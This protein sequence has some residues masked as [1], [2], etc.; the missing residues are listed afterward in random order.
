VAAAAAV[1][2]VSAVTVPVLA[3]RT[4]RTDR[5]LPPVEAPTSAA[6]TRAKAQRLLLTTLG[7]VS[8]ESGLAEVRPDG[9]VVHHKLPTGADD[10]VAMPDGHLLTL[11]TTDLQPGTKRADGPGVAG[12][13]IKLAVLTADGS[14][15]R[16]RE[17]R[18]KGEEVRLLG[19]TN[20]TA[21][22]RRTA[23][24]V[25]HD[26]ATGKERMVLPPSV[27]NQ[28]ASAWFPVTDLTGDRLA[29]AD[30][31]GSKGCT[32][33]VADLRTGEPLPV[34]GIATGTCIAE[35]VRLSPDGR[36][37][38]VAYLRLSETEKRVAV[39]DL[40]T[41]K[42]LADKPLGTRPVRDAETV[43]AA[44]MAWSD[45]RTVRVA[46]TELPPDAKRV[47]RLDEVLR[48][49]TVTA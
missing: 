21:Y 20:R 16:D 43:K 32:V 36:R 44:G 40:E 45:N 35:Q 33:R 22:L 5:P 23:G 31:N 7:E 2:V 27:L 14:V 10:V 29:V 34:R 19:A 3:G 28:P 9:S 4:G 47:Y 15:E 12:L 18:I 11:V 49:V 8:H 38:A 1:V 37:V 6:V 17:V 39:L 24:V 26:L 48:I 46:V 30:G 41:G 13:S 42:T 25:A